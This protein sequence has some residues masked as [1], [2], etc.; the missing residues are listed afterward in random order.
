MLALGEVSP[1]CLQAL[2]SPCPPLERSTGA[3]GGGRILPLPPRTERGDQGLRP[4]QCLGS[5]Q[6]LPKAGQLV[7]A[8]VSLVLNPSKARVAA[9]KINQSLFPPTASCVEGSNPSE[10]GK[11]RVE[12]PRL[13][14]EYAGRGLASGGGTEQRCE[15]K[16]SPPPPSRESKKTQRLSHAFQI[17]FPSACLCWQLS[18]L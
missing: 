9:G 6:G 2:C 10:C 7:P 4:I 12:R 8:A 14:A 5:L 15:R 17:A 3:G 13:G 1:G 18:R 11:E 16:F